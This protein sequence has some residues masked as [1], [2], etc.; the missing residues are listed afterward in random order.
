ML[1]KTWPHKTFVSI[2]ITLIL[3][4]NLFFFEAPASEPLPNAELAP[5]QTVQINPLIATAYQHLQ[6][7][8]PASA[9]ALYMNALRQE[10]GNRDALLGL[11]TVAMLLNDPGLA[12]HYLGIRLG[13]APDD[14]QALARWFD[15]AA[16][17]GTHE[18]HLQQILNLH[19]EIG[20]LHFA[21]G[22]VY[23]RQSRWSEARQSYENACRLDP[24]NPAFNFNLAISLDHL[25]ETPAATRYY[26]ESIRLNP[27][28]HAGIDAAAS[29]RLRETRWP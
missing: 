7:N 15:L 10:P 23:A 19:P 24:A 8:D 14:P 6:Q 5:Q 1:K 11:T 16:D 9:R 2:Q 21:L 17:N 26:R 18:N 4:G 25:G 3:L 28:H 29:T 13:R 22:N 27:H 20:G 12:L